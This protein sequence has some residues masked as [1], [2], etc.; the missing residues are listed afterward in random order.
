MSFGAD[1]TTDF[2][3]V[4]Q[5]LR[6]AAN[7]YIKN[8]VRSP[9]L[10]NGATSTRGSTESSSLSANSHSRQFAAFAAL[11]S[12]DLA[13]TCSRLESLSSLARQRTLFDDHSAEVQHLTLLIK[14]D[15]ANLNHRI[16]DLQ[17]L[18]KQQQHSHSSHQQSAKH[19]SSVLVSLQTRLAGMSE[20]FKKVLEQRSAT[21]QAQSVRKNAFTAKRPSVAPTMGGRDNV[22]FEGDSAPLQM[23]PA[24]VKPSILLQVS[25]YYLL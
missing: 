19:S 14:E 11:I 8:S 15:L 18:S 5:S 20:K 17:N 2:L 24:V 21:M 9:L 16:A 7:G 12:N 10:R 13:V 4:A 22:G 3:Q 1:R 6:P 25:H 23:T